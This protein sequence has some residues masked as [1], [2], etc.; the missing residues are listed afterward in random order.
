VGKEEH[1][2]PVPDPN[3]TMTNVPKE[4]SDT[5]TNTLIEEIL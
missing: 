5:Y 2:H 4:A 3:K 1:E